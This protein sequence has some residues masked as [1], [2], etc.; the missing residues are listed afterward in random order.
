LHRLLTDSHVGQDSQGR[1]QRRPAIGCLVL[2]PT[3]ELALQVQRSF[4]TYGAG[5]K[6]RQTAI[7]G[8]VSQNPQVKALQSGVQVVIATPGRLL[9]LIN[10]GHVRLD[11]LQILVLD[12]A[13]QMLDMGFIHDLR[14]IV[15]RVPA[16]RQTL[17][18]SATMP[19]EIRALAS[20]WL[21]RPQEVKV[22]PVA[23]T[24]ERVAQSVLFVERPEK[25][26]L[27]VQYL[28]AVERA[29]TLVFS[30]RKH[31]ADKLVRSLHRE[32]IRAVSIHGNKSQTAR[33]AAIRDFNSSRPPV[34]VATD[35]AAR[36]LDF[37]DVSH[38]IN[39]DLPDAPETYVHR[40]GRTARAGA[41]GKAVSFCG[42]DERR[43]LRTIE[44]LTGQAVAIERVPVPGVS[45][46]CANSMTESNEGLKECSPTPKEPR[47][48]ER[49]KAEFKAVRVD[50]AKAEPGRAGQRGKGRKRRYTQSSRQGESPV[51]TQF[52]RA[53][54]RRRRKKKQLAAVARTAAIRAERR[55]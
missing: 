24:P 15:S 17:M 25:V 10:Q 37:S 45:E 40:I 36:G 52:A 30:R 46:P 2:V 1:K 27:L 51:A 34:L 29:R 19:P 41:T 55:S 18:F 44:K 43:R 9:D 20:E 39:F 8:G 49:R 50:G 38:V 23:S 31:G 14:K 7:Y 28:N 47:R 48:K 32:G 13:D 33:Q 3:R 53:T 42:R 22:T 26:K 5:T 6:L 11:Q 4:Q 12:E 54:A 16:E 35:L 21:R